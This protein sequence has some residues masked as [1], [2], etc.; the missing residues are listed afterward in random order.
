MLQEISL[1]RNNRHVNMH[2]IFTVLQQNLKSILLKWRQHLVFVFKERNV[3]IFPFYFILVQ[4]SSQMDTSRSSSLSFHWLLSV[5]LTSILRNVQV[6]TDS[7]DPPRGTQTTARQRWSA[8]PPA[9]A[10]EAHEGHACSRLTKRCRTNTK[11]W[12][13]LGLQIIMLRA[14]NGPRA[15]GLGPVT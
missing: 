4:V 13:Q 15:T 3:A 5:Q 7:S 14:A 2:L 1:I 9:W 11:L 12:Y 6:L 10:M 8:W